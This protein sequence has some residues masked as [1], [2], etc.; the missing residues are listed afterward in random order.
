MLRATRAVL[1][2]Q[3]SG[4]AGELTRKN[5]QLELTS[6]MTSARRLVD[7]LC[8]FSADLFADGRRQPKQQKRRC[9]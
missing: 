4:D 3:M 8:N 6:S 1:G 5:N 2:A 7:T 9:L